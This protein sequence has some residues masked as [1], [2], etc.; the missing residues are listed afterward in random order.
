MAKTPKAVIR[1][2]A[3]LLIHH[4]C[5]S[6]NFFRNKLTNEIN[7][8]HHNRAPKN[9]PETTNK[10]DKIGDSTETISI[11]ANAATNKNTATGFDRVNKNTEKKS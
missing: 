3:I 2:P 6:L 11:L 4:N 1:T 5:F 8:T 10:V 7:M 9:T